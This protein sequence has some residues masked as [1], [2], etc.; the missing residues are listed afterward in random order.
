VEWGCGL[1]ACWSVYYVA[2]L[3]KG[4]VLLN[5]VIELNVPRDQFNFCQQQISDRLP[6]CSGVSYGSL[7]LR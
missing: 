1:P 2:K 3:R 6:E 7:N 5:R 4:D